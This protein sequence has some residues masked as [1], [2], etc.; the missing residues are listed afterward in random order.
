[1]GFES[2]SYSEVD[3]LREKFP[4]NTY[5][6][7]VVKS[8]EVILAKEIKSTDS[9]LDYGAGKRRLEPVIRKYSSNYFSFDPD[10]KTKQDFYSRD[11][12]V[13]VFDVII[14]RDV[15]EHMTYAQVDDFLI[16]AQKHSKKLILETLNPFSSQGNGAFFGDT[17]HKQ[18]YAPRA[19]FN[20]LITNKF[21]PVFFRLF[22]GSFFSI[23]NLLAKIFGTDICPAYICVA[24]NKNQAF[25]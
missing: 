12:I 20:F 8:L 4:L 15:A 21:E 2:F 16:W 9:V 10:T 11:K 13:G 17:D 1:M 24:Q 3:T 5:P 7:P 25:K 19:L 23:R 14:L 6:F 22:P 18:F